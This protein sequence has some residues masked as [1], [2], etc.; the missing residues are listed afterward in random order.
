MNRTWL[1]VALTALV[2]VVSVG[3][4]CA[5]TP[6]D[7]GVAAILSSIPMWASLVIMLLGL[8]IVMGLLY[9]LHAGPMV[10]VSVAVVLLAMFFLG[11][12]ATGRVGQW[13]GLPG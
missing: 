4:A 5:D 2:V 1:M 9:A 11:A 8:G 13:V 3:A 10:L 12:V 7:E 6:L